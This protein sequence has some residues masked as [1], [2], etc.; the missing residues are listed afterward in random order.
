MTGKMSPEKLSSFI[1]DTQKVSS[2]QEALSVDS[3]PYSF[4]CLLSHR[5]FCPLSSPALLSSVPFQH[6]PAQHPCAAH[7]PQ[8]P[9]SPL[10]S[11]QILDT[12]L[13]QSWLKTHP[14]GVFLGSEPLQPTQALTVI[15]DDL[16]S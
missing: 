1:K 6:P 11:D 15:P 8:L 10:L 3:F 7:C 5:V 9:G 14:Q 2:I 12:S 13:F 4:C 16:T